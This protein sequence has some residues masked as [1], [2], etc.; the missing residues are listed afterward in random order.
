MSEKSF[1]LPT[2]QMML[3][4]SKRFTTA[5][6]LLQNTKKY[7]NDGFH[8]RFLQN[9]IQKITINS[10]FIWCPLFAHFHDA[11]KSIVSR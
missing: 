5:T 10:R 2:L 11:L 8:F 1:S 4:F 3:Y 7:F 6:D 9:K